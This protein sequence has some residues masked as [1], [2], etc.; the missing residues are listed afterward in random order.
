MSELRLICIDAEAPP[1]FS[2]SHDGR[3]DGYEP[4]A[5]ALVADQLGRELRWVFRPWQ[6]MVPALIAGEGDG[7]WCGQGIT[8]ERR[9][10]VDF[11][12]PYAVFD[13]AALVRTGSGVTG[14]EDLRGRRVGA[15]AHSTNMALAETFEGAVTVA[16]DGSSGDVFGEMIA[17]LR[18]GE[19]DALIDDDVALV[20]LDDDAAFEVAFTVPTRNAWGISVSKQRPEWREELDGALAAVIDDGRLETVWR[21]WMPNLAFPFGSPSP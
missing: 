2:K 19:I 18:A 3:R 16:F 12:R 6:E 9:K 7:V 21:R 1:L 10:L 17:A 4:D 5:A 11:T 8:A 13:E 14:P 20:P 15:I